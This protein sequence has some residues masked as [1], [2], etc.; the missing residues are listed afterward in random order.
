MV[1]RRHRRHL[2]VVTLVVASIAGGVTTASSSG[3]QES[4][5]DQARRVVTG[6][7]KAFNRHDSRAALAYFTSDRRFIKNVSA[8]DCDFGHGVTVG[9]S[10]KAEVARWLRERAADHDQFTIAKI[11]L[12]GAR[13]SGAVVTYSR[14][15]E[16]HPCIEGT[17]SGYRAV[18]WNQDRLYNRRAGA[19]DSVCE[20]R[21]HPLALR[22]VVA[23]QA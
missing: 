17:P 22:A 21:G 16:R 5:K 14:T 6:F 12:V 15:D 9:Y 8:S 13:P 23:P 19:I 7:I 3:A 2:A 10:G 1:R 11:R 18:E 20:R 4:R